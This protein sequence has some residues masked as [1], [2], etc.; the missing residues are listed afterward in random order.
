MEIGCQGTVNRT[1]N[2]AQKDQHKPEWNATIRIPVTI[3]PLPREV[4]V[5]KPK[6]VK[7]FSSDEDNSEYGS[8]SSEESDDIHFE[9]FYQEMADTYASYG[10]GKLI[11]ASFCTA[12]SAQA[13]G[14]AAES[15]GG[16]GGWLELSDG[17]GKILYTAKV[18]PR[19]MPRARDA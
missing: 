19:E 10:R 2:A 8:D 11:L 15:W 5:A 6:G 9:V 14:P 16:K 18:T 12:C 3:P 4:S 7:E 13:G 1:P 17:S